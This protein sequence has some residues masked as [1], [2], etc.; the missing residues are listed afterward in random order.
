MNQEKLLEMRN[1]T[2]S[3][4]QIQVEPTENEGKA[5]RENAH[6][7]RDERKETR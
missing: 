3:D 7:K 6:V 5:D 2:T 1:R 4:A